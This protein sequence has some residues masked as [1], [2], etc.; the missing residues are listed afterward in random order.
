VAP[1]SGDWG[2][3][4]RVRD[5]ESSS[6]D[7]ESGVGARTRLAP[8]LTAGSFGKFREE[9]S[10]WFDHRD[11]RL[12]DLDDVTLQ[13]SSPG[14]TE[15]VSCVLDTYGSYTPG[16]AEVNGTSCASKD[17]CTGPVTSLKVLTL[18]GATMIFLLCG[19]KTACLDNDRTNRGLHEYTC[20]MPH[21]RDTIRY[22]TKTDNPD[23]M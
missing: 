17:Y 18:S 19:S 20:R 2:L 16:E 13:H 9:P 22:H 12:F 14:L 11:R 8:G 3:G 10:V 21:G 7:S 1:G 23:S 4:R 6:G 15:T 5:L